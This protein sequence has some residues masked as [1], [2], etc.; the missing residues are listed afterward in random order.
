MHACRGHCRLGPASPPL[1]HLPCTSATRMHESTP[2]APPNASTQM[3]VPI[4][5]RA[6]KQLVSQDSHSNTY[7][8]KYTFSVE[9]APICK[10]GGPGLGVP[11]CLCVRPRKRRVALRPSWC[12]WLRSCARCVTPRPSP[13]GPLVPSRRTPPS[14]AKPRQP[15]AKPR[16]QDDLV[17]LSAK[18]C[19]ALGHLGPLVLVARVTNQI[20]LIDPI[21]LR[22]HSMDVSAA[23]GGGGSAPEGSAP[24]GLEGLRG[25]VGAWRPPTRVCLCGVCCCWCSREWPFIVL[26]LE[27]V[28]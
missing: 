1:L 6:D 20:T 22:T 19:S 15:C 4:K 7:N 24:R 11:T 8:Y 9:I 12:G 13:P 28:H 14:L 23:G 25:A 27:R 17:C 5:F 10:V 21:T 3:V 26:W 16:A 2:D 18:L